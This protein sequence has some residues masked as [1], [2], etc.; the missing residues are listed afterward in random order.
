Q[1]TAAPDELAT[2]AFA[3]LTAERV[4]AQPDYLHDLARRALLLDVPRSIK[5]RAEVQ[6]GE[7]T[8][9]PKRHAATTGLVAMHDLVGAV[10]DGRV[11]NL[12]GL[13]TD[14]LLGISGRV[15]ITDAIAVH[16]LVRLHDVRQ[17]LGRDYGQ[18]ELLVQIASLMLVTGQS[19][20]KLRQALRGVDG[21]PAGLARD[22]DLRTCA[23]EFFDLSHAMVGQPIRLNE[24]A[25]LGEMGLRTGGLS[26]VATSALTGRLPVAVQVD[27]RYVDL[28]TDETFV[29]AVE[30]RI[31]A[32]DQLVPV[33]T[34]G[35]RLHGQPLS[36][37]ASVAR[38][39]TL[40]CVRPQRRP[41]RAAHLD[42]VRT[43]ALA[44]GDALESAT[45]AAAMDLN[46]ASGLLVVMLAWGP[47]PSEIVRFVPSDI[48]A[49]RQAVQCRAKSVYATEERLF[50]YTPFIQELLGGF[51]DTARH[52]QLAGGRLFGCFTSS[53]LRRHFQ[54][55]VSR[56]V[57]SA[58]PY[59]LY[60][61]RHLCLTLRD[62][63]A[64][65]GELQDWMFKRAV[66]GHSP[67]L[68][69]DIA[70]H[71]F[72]E[73]CERADVY[74]RRLL[75]ELGLTQRTLYLGA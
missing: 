60:Q 39:L 52:Q 61:Y 11:A 4:G 63:W 15:T 55:I 69:S 14:A 21:A 31:R 32:L 54:E 7:L 43:I 48:S 3:V 33:V 68:F 53:H 37:H 45:G 59:V 36:F 71:T 26:P 40:A 25:T 28:P 35:W 17:F 8:I 20:E 6:L 58:P 34:R 16:I 62:S 67:W 5:T 44:L 50:P 12:E 30:K 75:P 72:T 47:R 57:P 51:I 2:A 66:D 49:A 70:G 19:L 29:R 22:D 10:T 46:W 23:E 56:V 9:T 18:H 27:A 42:D 74:W 38:S 73:L 1:W 41:S 64:R 24:L 13:G 65:T